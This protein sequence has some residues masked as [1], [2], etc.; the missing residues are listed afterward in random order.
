M[1]PFIGVVADVLGRRRIIVIAIVLLIVPTALIAAAQSLD[2]IVALRFVQG[3]LLPPVFAVAIAYIG[4]EFPRER[5]AAVTATYIT[6]S[7]L[8]GFSGRF[9]AGWVGDYAG[10]RAAYLALAAINLLSA[11]VVIALLPRE[12]RF[13]RAEGL[14][15]SM[16]LMARHFRDPRLAATFAVGFGMLFCFVT[17]FTFINF[18]LADPPFDFSAADLGTLFVVYLFGAV[19]T[20]LTG[21]LVARLG[22]RRLVVG[23]LALWAFGVFLTLLPHLWPI[24]AGLVIA[25]CC[26]FICQAVSTGYVAYAATEARSS[27]VGLYV[28]AYY[29]GGS[30]GATVGGFAWHG[31]GW[32]GCVVLVWLMQAI[33]AGFVLRFWREPR[34]LAA[35]AVRD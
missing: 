14:V 35:A 6:G 21:R 16:T 28:T 19:T 23:A 24:L 3:L 29:L 15:R 33:M 17:I 26:G 31:A 27:A 11:L 9:V 12:R 4:D 13:V 2:Q 22:R 30:V 10:W 20:P 25:A 5:I 18:H 32:L 7:V 1:A 34:S 8:G